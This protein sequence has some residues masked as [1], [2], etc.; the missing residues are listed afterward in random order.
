MILGLTTTSFIVIAG[1]ALGTVALAGFLIKKI[2]ESGS[3]EKDFEPTTIENMIEPEVRS[4]ATT[5]GRSVKAPLRYGYSR[6]GTVYKTLPSESNVNRDDQDED[7]VDESVL[8]Q[9]Y[10]DGEISERTCEMLKQEGEEDINVYFVRKKGIIGKVKLVAF[11]LLG[12]EEKASKVVIVPERLTR[13]DSKYLTIR[14]DAEMTRFA[15]MD[16][17]KEPS[18]YRYIENIAYRQLYSQALEDQKNYHDKVNFYDSNFSQSIQEL[19]AEARAEKSKW[20]G[21]GTGMVEED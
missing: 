4:L 3:E 17:A 12:S 21:K 6:I 5:W 19:K 15:G 7:R 10:E 20:E 2:T 14:K 1:A 13:V 11:K 18:T 8:T 9:A 16:V